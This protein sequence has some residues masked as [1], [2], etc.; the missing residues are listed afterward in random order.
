MRGQNDSKLTWSR[1]DEVGGQRGI[2][3]VPRG[4]IGEAVLGLTVGDRPGGF[5]AVVPDLGAHVVDAGCP[6]DRS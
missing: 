3:E 6:S 1:V 2:G 4:V 5:A